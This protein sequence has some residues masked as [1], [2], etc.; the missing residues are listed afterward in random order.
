MYNP[1]DTAAKVQVLDLPSSGTAP[2]AQMVSVAAHGRA[3]VDVGNRYNAL[4]PHGTRTESAQVTSDVPVVVD[5]ALYWGAGIGPAKYGYSLSP[6]SA[7]P[8]G[9]QAFA[10]APSAS[11]TQTYATVLNPATV[12]AMVSVSLLDASGRRLKTISARLEGMRRA[13]F[14]FGDLLPTVGGSLMVSSAAPVVA[15]APVYVGGSPNQG[16]HAGT[17]LGPDQGRLIAAGVVTK[18]GG[19]LE[20]YNSGTGAARVQA[21]LSTESGRK[22]LSDEVVMAGQSVTLAVPA[23]NEARGVLV[24][25]SGP[26]VTTLLCNGDDGSLSGETLL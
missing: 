7:A 20:L 19:T 14:S 11:G 25:A 9:V 5:R 10:L 13:T 22:T 6:A 26:L 16:A 3:T 2:A 1:G 21:T 8:A 17:V 4:A 12:A 18:A 15:E 23:G 24:L